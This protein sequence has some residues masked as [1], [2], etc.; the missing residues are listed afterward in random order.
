MVAKYDKNVEKTLAKKIREPWLRN[1][2]KLGFKARRIQVMDIGHNIK[3]EYLLS[4]K[5]KV[6][7]VLPCY[8]KQ[9]GQSTVFQLVVRPNYCFLASSPAKLLFSSQKSGQTTVFQL[10][11]RPN[12]CFL[13]SSPAKILISSQQSLQTT[14]F[15][16]V[17]HTNYCFPACSP[18]KLLFSSYQSVQTTVFQLCCVCLSIYVSF[19]LSF[20]L[21][22]MTRFKVRLNDSV[23]LRTCLIEIEYCLN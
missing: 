11:V 19:F 12:Y 8:K 15:Q 1:Y 23:Q 14:V 22:P 7:E 9:S 3:K 17:I 16:L 10:N 20:F 18:S 2:K 21:Q 4:N 6:L 5:A 13:A